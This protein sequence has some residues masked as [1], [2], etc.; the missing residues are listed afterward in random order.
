METTTTT[1]FVD[2][3]TAANYEANAVVEDLLKRDQGMFDSAE[4]LSA[5]DLVDTAVSLT[6]DADPA[7]LAAL[8]ETSAAGRAKASGQPLLDAA[9]TKGGLLLDLWAGL[10]SLR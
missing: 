2:I 10:E 5:L 8:S 6:T 1:T 4:V 7:R 9:G 3:A